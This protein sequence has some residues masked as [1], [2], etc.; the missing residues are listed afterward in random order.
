MSDYPEQYRDRMDCL[1]YD[2]ESSGQNEEGG[3][4]GVRRLSSSYLREIGR[5]PLL[6]PEEEQKYAKIF[7]ET[8]LK[9]KNYCDERKAILAFFLVHEYNAGKISAIFDYLVATA[10]E[11]RMKEKILLDALE[12]M[13]KYRKDWKCVE[14]FQELCQK[15]SFFP[16]LYFDCMEMLFDG[17]EDDFSLASKLVVPARKYLVDIRTSL[18]ASRSSLIEA[19]LRLVITIARSYM[20]SNISIEDLV[21]EGNIGLMRAVESFDFARGN[22]FSTYASYWVRQ[23]IA[24]AV[25]FHGRLIRMPVHVIRELSRI[26]RCERIMLQENDGRVPTAEE[27][28]K[29]LQMPAVRIKA[30][31]RMAQQPISLCSI[32]P[33]GKNWEEMLSDNMVHAPQAEERIG[34]MRGGLEDALGVLDNRERDIIVRHFGLNGHESETLEHIG[35]SFGLTSERIRQIESAAL[36]KM[37][38]PLSKS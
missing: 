22:R 38:H 6:S 32:E 17:S 24:R 28:G 34:E 8:F 27:I 12:E 31:Q 7:R 25:N 23:S 11:S 3:Y 29:L 36:I 30:L 5:I 20:W 18:H 33:E 21:Q 37:R 13:S 10:V 26:S 9:L 35:A 19:N 4:A 15:C 14:L 16:S 1:P 2:G